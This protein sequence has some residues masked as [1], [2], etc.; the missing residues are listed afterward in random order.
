MI[1]LFFY[2]IMCQRS[3]E[4]NRRDPPLLPYVLY[5]WAW[6]CHGCN[7]IHACDSDSSLFLLRST[8]YCYKHLHSYKCSCVA[9]PGQNA[10]HILKLHINLKYIDKEEECML[11]YK[12]SGNHILYEWCQVLWILVSFEYHYGGLHHEL[13]YTSFEVPSLYSPI[14]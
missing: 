1:S 14:L 8:C 11:N 10:Q 3:F 9:S 5:H 4:L 2:S 13:L 12:L 6:Q 7:V